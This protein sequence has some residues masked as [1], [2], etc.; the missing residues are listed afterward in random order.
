V[1]V[2]SG[3]TPPKRGFKAVILF[4]EEQLLGREKHVD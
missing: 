3:S 2:K 4:K 1:Y